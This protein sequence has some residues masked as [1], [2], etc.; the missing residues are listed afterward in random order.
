[1]MRG[2]PAADDAEGSISVV[3]CCYTLDRWDE[4]SRAISSVST[5]VHSAL[6]TIVVVD[7]NDELHARAQE[8]WANESVTVVSN[9]QRQGLSGARNTGVAIA[10]GSIVAFLDDDAHAAPDWLGHLVAPYEDASVLGVG[11]SSLAAWAASRPGWFPVEFDWVVGCTYLGQPTERADVRN[12]IGSNMSFRRSVFRQV[13]DFRSDIGRI[14]TR[15]LGCEE[16]ELCIRAQ[17]GIG[18][19]R[20][21]FEP[22]AIVHHHVP[23]TRGRLR[24]F[25]ARCWAEGQSKA[26][27]AKIA[28]PR[29]GLATE[30]AYVRRT[31]PQG[32]VRSLTSVFRGEI[33]GLGRAAA[34]LSGLGITTAG[35]LAGVA[36]LRT[37]R[38][39]IDVGAGRITPESGQ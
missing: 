6:E 5:Q 7:H 38:L 21:V 16:T 39:A 25:I 10:R 19:G 37:G 20:I 24:Y 30:R 18:G 1:M 9:T 17:A 4:I 15:P 29:T 32:V 23:E 11:G 3:I 8:A 2:K 28:G 35:Y 14:G 26:M 31:L 13:G 34:I 12:V 22:R 33:S 36:A 27:V